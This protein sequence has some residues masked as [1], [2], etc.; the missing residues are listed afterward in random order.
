ML[1]RLSA[2]LTGL[3][4]ALAAIASAVLAALV[5]YVVFERF[6]MSTT[7]H[8]A[9]ELPRLVLVWAAFVGGVVCGFDR[10]HLVAGMLP[11]LVR[12]KR[13]LRAVDRFNQ[14]VIIVGLS[15]L[16]YAGWSL[17][18]ITMGQTLPALG[19][20]AGMVYL[21]L[22]V[23]CAAAVIV[24]LAQLFEPSDAATPAT[25]LPKD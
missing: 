21:A 12:S 11:Y 10:S 14:V 17:A 24:H 18:Q 20:S 7:P 4:R 15:V 19:I 3:C 23:G 22:P 1:Q 25:P 8:W 16:G 6:V 2:G 9:E 13:V 5:T